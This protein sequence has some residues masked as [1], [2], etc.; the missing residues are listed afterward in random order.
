MT[1]LTSPALRAGTDAHYENAR[2]YDQA[3]RL[4]REDAAF[5]RRQADK[6]GGPVLELGVGTGRVARVLAEGGHEVLGVDSSETM[7]EQARLRAQ[8]L[9]KKKQN[10]LTFKRGDLRNFR[11]KR[12]FPLVIAPFNV[13][14]H[15]YSRQDWE[16]GLATVRHHLLP[17]GRFVFDVMLPDPGE[18]SRDPDR[19]YRGPT[20]SVPGKEGPYRYGESF[21]YDPITQV[22]LVTMQFEPKKRTKKAAATDDGFITPLCHRQVFP[23]ELEALLHYNGFSIKARYGDFEG[24]ELSEESESQVVVAQRRKGF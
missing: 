8:K 16:R 2:Y 12:R 7:L 24:D 6:F 23:A 13:L 19:V 21:E 17:K 10:L 18:L 22:Q 3:Y 1:K 20:V 14:M 4:R 5:Y 11:T 15:L 9:P